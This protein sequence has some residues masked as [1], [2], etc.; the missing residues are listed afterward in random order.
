MLN[1]VQLLALPN[2]PL[3]RPGDDLSS[4]IMAACRQA[5]LSLT[6]ADIVVVAQKIVSKAE[7]Q[8]VRLAEVMPSPRAQEVAAI[9]AK[10]APLVEVILWDT[11]EIIRMQKDLLIVEHKLGFISANAG[12]DH[13][14]VSS[15]PDVVL[16]L[17]QNPDA[18]ARAIRRGL[19]RLGGASPP[20][21]IIDSHG[22]PWRWGTVG[23]TIGLS[24]LAPV[25]NLRGTPDLF[26]A[27]LQHTDVGFTDQI[28]A[29]ASLLMG[30]AAERCP[31]VIVRGL[32]FRPDEQARAADVLRPKAGD[33]FR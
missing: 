9:T 19:A 17:P 16:R 12:V 33:V 1:T 6:G 10:P 23:V 15:E 30:Q 4:L 21:L 2:I 31:V 18:S 3:V 5:G 24:G 14:N 25:Q 32:A 27:P 20:V 28:A 8:F 22:R 7:G 11:A 13:S 29:A 26:G